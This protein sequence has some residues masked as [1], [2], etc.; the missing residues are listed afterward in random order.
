MK[1]FDTRRIVSALMAGSLLSSLTAN[2]ELRTFTIDH[3]QTSLNFSGIF[4]TLTLFPQQAGSLTARY[5]GTIQTD[6][7]SSNITFL[8]AS[9]VASNSGSWQP[10][11]GG[12]SGSAPSNYGGQ[13]S[14]P[15]VSG[16]AAVRN[17]LL[18]ITSG[19][20]TITGTNFP[21]QNTTFIVPTNA[22]TTFDFRY[23]G[24]INGSGTRSLANN[25]T[26]NVADPGNIRTQGQTI[27]LTMPVN[28]DGYAT[29][30]SPNDTHYFLMGQIV[31]TAPLTPPAPLQFTDFRLSGSQLVYTMS[32][33]SNQSY[34][35][36]GSSNLITWNM[37]NDQFTA[38]NSQTTRTIPVPNSS[39]LF[40]RARQN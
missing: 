4:V 23:S 2:A 5:T 37:T 36:L 26:N 6:L 38:T 9:M 16:V 11:P 10:L 27:I 8:G 20:L 14:G 33:I 32:T 3:S 18:N 39:R 34:A 17:I 13:G 29:V 1:T 31:A 40:F 22:S 15:G 25:S 12:G 35:I 19:S 21:A 30:N 7:T 24:L 28:V